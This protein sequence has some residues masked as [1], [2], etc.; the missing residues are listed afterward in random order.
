[1]S[2][3]REYVDVDVSKVNSSQ[4]NTG[5]T[6][7]IFDDYGLSSIFEANS[8]SGKNVEQESN[9]AITSAIRAQLSQYD[10]LPETTLPD[11]DYKPEQEY[12][13]NDFDCTVYKNKDGTSII[14]K[15]KREDLLCSIISLASGNNPEYIVEEY[16]ENSKLTKRTHDL[17]DGTSV[18]SIIDNDGKVKYQAQTSRISSS[19]Q[20]SNSEL[21]IRNY[22]KDGS[23]TLTTTRYQV[24]K[25]KQNCLPECSSSTLCYDKNNNVQWGSTIVYT[26]LNSILD[27]IVGSG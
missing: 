12:S 18:V 16:N 23:Y 24:D 2:T 8:S 14:V 15:K 26:L 4:L 13:E 20:Y 25:T 17:G 11:F 5:K 9:Y 7:T 6:G 22:N 10:L 21:K 27:S 3:N 19:Q 1:M